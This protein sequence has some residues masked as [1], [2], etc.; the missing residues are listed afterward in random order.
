MTWVF[1]VPFLSPYWVLWDPIIWVH[2]V[3]FSHTAMSCR[4]F[5][6][7]NPKLT[8]VTLIFT[9]TA[10]RYACLPPI[11]DDMVPFTSDWKKART[12]GISNLGGNSQDLKEDMEVITDNRG[13]IKEM[14][15]CFN[16]F[17][18]IS[19]QIKEI[20]KY[21]VPK[22]EVPFLCILNNFVVTQ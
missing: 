13:E 8:I 4:S 10:N 18:S 20:N 14:D 15:I 6:V 11:K 2:R 21:T 12:A 17:W 16:F 3:T 22:L 7:W 5:T 9:S 19:E 1:R